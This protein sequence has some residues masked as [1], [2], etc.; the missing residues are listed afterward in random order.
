MRL[1]DVSEHG[2]KTCQF[3][4]DRGRLDL[5]IRLLSL[6]DRSDRHELPDGCSLESLNLIAVTSVSDASLKKRGRATLLIPAMRR[7]LM[8]VLG[9]LE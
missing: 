7:F 6:A 2:A 8:R 3:T 5:L 4:I 1:T 9:P